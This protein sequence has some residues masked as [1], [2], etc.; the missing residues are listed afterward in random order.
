[1]DHSQ[2]SKYLEA[3]HFKMNKIKGVIAILE[4]DA[5]LAKIDL[6]NAYGHIPLNSQAAYLVA[7]QETNYGGQWECP[8]ALVAPI[9]LH[10]HDKN[11]VERA[12]TKTTRR[13]IP[14]SPGDIIQAECTSLKQMMI[15]AVVTT[16]SKQSSQR[17]T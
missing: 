3:P 10:M 9:R 2:L 14:D 16:C 7:K 4:P 11:R 13:K 5:Y 15:H 17:E 1:M 12:Q 8:I 6:T